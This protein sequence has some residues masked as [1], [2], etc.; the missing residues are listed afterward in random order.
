MLLIHAMMC[1]NLKSIMLRARRQTWDHIHCITTGCIV[2][3][4][5]AK[6][7]TIRSGNRS[8]IAGVRNQGVGMIDCKG[9]QGN[10]GGNGNVL[11][12]LIA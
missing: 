8:M 7:K 5:S 9:I 3:Q 6:G 10:F 1:I 2:M 11:Y 12:V 4:S